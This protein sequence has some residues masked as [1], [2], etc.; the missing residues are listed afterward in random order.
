MSLRSRE[1]LQYGKITSVTVN[2]GVLVD[3]DPPDAFLSI[4]AQL[5]SGSEASRTFDFRADSESIIKLMYEH[6]ITTD[7]KQLVGKLV[8][9]DVTDGKIV[10]YGA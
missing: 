3:G 4:V 8:H 9:V 10:G 5:A 7:F 6:N 1:N 2:V